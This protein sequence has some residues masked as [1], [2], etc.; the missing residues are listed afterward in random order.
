MSGVMKI[1]TIVMKSHLLIAIILACILSENDFFAQI[2]ISKQDVTCHDCT[3][4][5]A[6]VSVTGGT[7]PYEYLWPGGSSASSVSGLA[8]GYYVVIINDANGCSGSAS[9]TINDQPA[10]PDPFDISIVKSLDPNDIT[11]PAGY[12]DSKWVSVKDELPYLIRF[13][14]DSKF[15]TSAVNKVVVT[16]PIDKMANMFSF[17]L[18]D[19]TF[20]NFS[21]HIPPNTSHYFKR[22]NL[23]DSIGVYLDVTA[24]I[25]VTKNQAFWIFQAFDPVSGLQNINPDLGFLLINDSI[26]HN[27][28]G[29]VSFTIKPK[30][31]ALT[32]F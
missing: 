10:P 4:G 21:Y 1:K 29:S 9:V 24:G 15:A 28:E 19:F 23:V 30:N 2:T 31:N 25:D 20:R 6:A 13:E 17:Q 11:G 7:P 12:G 27:G 3:D 16:H 8:P 18:G 5:T 26:T 22:L 14:N 32:G